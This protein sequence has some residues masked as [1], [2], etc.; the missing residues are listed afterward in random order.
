MAYG[1]YD[2]EAVWQLTFSYHKE[3]YA[4]YVVEDNSKHGMR[5]KMRKKWGLYPQW[6]VYG[7]IQ[8]EDFDPLAFA[9]AG[10]GSA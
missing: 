1:E 3:K 10:N 7:T 8:H 9:K 6:F 4:P 2:Y 5:E